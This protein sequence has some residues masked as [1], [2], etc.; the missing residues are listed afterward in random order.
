MSH[1]QRTYQRH[2]IAFPV[3]VV[4]LDRCIAGVS[5]DVSVGGMFVEC[6]ERVPFGDKVQL[7]F[8][9]PSLGR[10]IIAE[11]L[12]RWV[13][14]AAGIGVQFTGLRAGEVWAFQQL[15]RSLGAGRQESPQEG[16]G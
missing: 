7:R 8:E 3:E 2:T 14:P 16:T 15:I 1:N 13:D 4:H 5:R 12:V 9:L 10:V 11:A 6:G